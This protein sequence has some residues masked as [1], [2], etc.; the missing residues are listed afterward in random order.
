MTTSISEPIVPTAED[1]V[2]AKKARR[3]LASQQDQF[4]SLHVQIVQKRKTLKGV[5]LPL[6]AVRLVFAIIDE[7]LVGN[8]VMLIPVHAELTTQEAVDVLNVSHTF[9]VNLLDEH[10]IPYRK[11]GTHQRIL[12]AD[13]MRYKHRGKMGLVCPVLVAAW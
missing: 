4:M 1:A 11:V 5:L 7:M 13:L 10:K 8:A 3:A 2:L 12:F 9:L 6:S